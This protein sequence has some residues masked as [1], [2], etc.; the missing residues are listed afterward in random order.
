MDS[1]RK[2]ISLSEGMD[3]HVARDD[4][5]HTSH[6]QSRISLEKLFT[7]R[8]IAVSGSLIGGRV[9]KPVLDFYSANVF[10][11]EKH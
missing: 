10:G 7:Q 9:H 4:D 5:T 2:R 11:R 6:C 1:N 3:M 8:A